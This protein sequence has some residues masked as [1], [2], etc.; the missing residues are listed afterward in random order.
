[1]EQRKLN[2]AKIFRRFGINKKHKDRLFQRVFSDKK[3]LLD[4]YNAINHTSYANPDELEITTLEDVIY[5]SMKNDMSFIISS[6]LNLYEHQST[7]NPNMPLRGFMYFAR[8]YEAYIKQHKLD[9]YGRSLVRLPRPQFIVF[10]NG[11]DEYPDKS[12]LKLSDAFVPNIKD[13]NEEVLECRATMLN[14]NYGH[15]S[16]LLDRCRRLHDYAYFIAAI[17]GYAANGD[18]MAEAI[19]KAV[20]QC[21]EEN[22]LA[23]ILI[24]CRSEVKDMLLTEFDEKLYKKT[25]YREGYEDG[26]EC[27]ISEGHKLG[28]N[29]GRELGL[30]EGREQGR[31]LGVSEAHEQDIRKSIAMLR[32]VGVSDDRIADM[33]AE[34]YDVSREEILKKINKI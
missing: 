5:M 9:I 10:Y 18:T 1:M 12:V 32:N 31:R 27:G 3:D 13:S 28:L 2:I 8:L 11:R 14:I 6:T 15:N 25:V 29:E 33:I 22:I 34:N 20:E 30:S 19:D 23:D 24:K 26:H 17:N 4:L 21:I 7:F 16:V